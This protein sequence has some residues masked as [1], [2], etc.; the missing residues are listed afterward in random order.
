MTTRSWATTRDQPGTPPRSQRPKPRTIHGV[1]IDV[2]ESN[3]VTHATNPASRCDPLL[4]G[5]VVTGRRRLQQPARLAASGASSQR[6]AHR[7]Y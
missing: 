4:G 6:L 5:I 1:P 7:C 2:I 3:F